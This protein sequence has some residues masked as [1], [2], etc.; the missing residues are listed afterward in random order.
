MTG[1]LGWGGAQKALAECDL[2]LMLGTDFPYR[3]FLESVTTVIQVDD[4]PLHLGRRANIELGLVGDVGE[5]LRAL[6][7]RLEAALG[8]PLPRR[9]R[10][11]PPARRQAPAD[12][13]RP[14]GKRRRPAA[15]D[16]RGRAE[17]P[18]RGRRGVHGR[19]GHVQRLGRAL[20]ADEARAAHPRVVQPRLDGELDAAGDRRQDREPGAPGDRALRRRRLLDADGRAADG[21]RASRSRSS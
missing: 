18:R 16:G 12:L 7:P 20:P 6:L 10:R 9:H 13:R 21:G 3:A 8:Q 15:R 2:L 4:K 19:H 14:S 1:L 17:R 11:S 5:T